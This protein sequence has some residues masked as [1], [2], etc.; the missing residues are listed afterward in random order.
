MV[1][2]QE[3][4]TLQN[5]IKKLII[6]AVPDV[7]L[8]TLR[9]P[10]GHYATTQPRDMLAHIMAQY[11][12]ITPTD[13]A[14]NMERIQAPWNP[15][16]SIKHLL[17]RGQDCRQFATEGGNPI[18]EIAYL[19]ILIT[20]I[21]QSGVMADDIKTWAMKASQDQTLDNAIEH[22]TKATAFQRENK[23]Y[24]KDT[25]TAHQA[26]KSQ[27]TVPT[28][29]L[30][31][32]PPLPTTHPLHGYT[33]CWTHGVCTHSGAQCKT[34]APGQVPTA[35]LGNPQGGVVRVYNPNARSGRG[36]NRNRYAGVDLY[37][38]LNP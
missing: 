5:K 7:Y 10:R 18:D 8:A 3:A 14:T 19:Q 11:G 31:P 29:T 12:T 13:L 9:Q 36:H 22:F 28:L 37:T 32:A 26:V 15:D 34:P 21:R 25:M 16:T 6:Q 20:I 27:P 2:F 35:T 38:G 17:T 30:P 33:Y 4:K 24:L 23:A 1:K